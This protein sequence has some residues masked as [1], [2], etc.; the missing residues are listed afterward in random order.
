MG[1]P[2]TI[3]AAANKIKNM[4]VVSMVEFGCVC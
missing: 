1:D 4:G 2:K 3:R